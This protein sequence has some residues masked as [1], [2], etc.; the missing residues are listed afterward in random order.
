MLRS[1]WL[2]LVL[3]SIVLAGCTKEEGEG[4][5]AQ[6][7]GR[8]MTQDYNNN[9]NEIA[10]GS[11]YPT[12]EHRVYIIYGD[13]EFNDDDVRTGGD[14]RFR[15]P[16]LQKG[17][18]TIYTVSEVYRSLDTP[19]GIEVIYRTVNIKKKDEKVD[20]GDIPIKRYRL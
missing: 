10:V 8:I 7:V 15:F 14:G 3:S 1:H 12:P 2:V 19:S 18:Y 11:P 16:E 5:R 20:L 6:I 9:P 17:K 4:G 13:N